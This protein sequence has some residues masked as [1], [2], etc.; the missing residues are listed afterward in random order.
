MQVAQLPGLGGAGGVAHQVGALGRF[1]EGNHFADAIR[2]AQHGD[3]PVEA[4]CDAAVRRCAVA[5]RL[6][7]V[8]E[9]FLRHVG[10]NL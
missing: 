5:E 3:E 7:H 2:V 8:A 6:K 4:K 1:W 9:P 10:W